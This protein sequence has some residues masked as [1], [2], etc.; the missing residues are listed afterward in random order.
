MAITVRL[1]E[2]QEEQLGELMK[3]TGKAT[4]SGAVEYMIENGKDLIENNKR[5]CEIKKLEKEMVLIKE[6]IAEL[7]TSK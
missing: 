5:F 4:K 6:T 1:T 3:L 2:E 7:L